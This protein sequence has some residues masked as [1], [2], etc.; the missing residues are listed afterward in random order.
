ML[1]VL[2]TSLAVI[3]VVGAWLI[4]SA[5]GLV[6][7]PGPVRVLSLVV[8][9]AVIMVVLGGARGMRRMTRPMGQLIEAAGRIESGDYS[10]R[11][12]EYGPREL[13]SVA[14]AFNAMSARLKASDDQR[15]SFLADVAHELRTPLSVIRGQAE[16]IADG[17]YPGDADHV[18]PILD[19]TQ[20]LEILVED[21]RTLALTDAG[22]LVL[23][24]EAVDPAAL[25]HDAL[26]AF[27][28]Q[29]ERGGI[30]LSADI[31]EDVPM[32][33]VDAARLRGVLANLL[34]N[35]MRH[36]HA[37]GSVRIG[38]RPLGD[39]VVISV[40]DTGEGIAPE[41]LP[42]V[43]ER[44]VRG[45]NSTGSGLGLAI[46]HDIIT[47]HGGKVDI[48]SVVGSGTTVRLTVPSVPRTS[49]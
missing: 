30:G 28:T 20:T 17:V 18:A 36:T 19:A 34:S 14:R 25:V 11:V 31:A 10:T 4:A 1:A 44:F 45:P 33:D 15:R 35:S 13:R 38:A 47:A 3:A 24:R 9:L 39:Q 8:L 6:Q 5:V 26:A 32:V 37:G 23:N 7:T 21:L 43:F 42:R 40:T 2:F 16:A 12:A 29:A 49:N 27:K 41:L 48:E 46:A 22:S